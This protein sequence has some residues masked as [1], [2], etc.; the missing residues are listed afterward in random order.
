MV[1]PTRHIILLY[2]FG[3]FSTFAS[4]DSAGSDAE[5]CDDSN[6][7]ETVDS[8]RSLDRDKGKLLG[9]LAKQASKS[10]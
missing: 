7:A 6:E 3:R 10:R 2:G 1:H 5:C 4:L 8:D 9:T